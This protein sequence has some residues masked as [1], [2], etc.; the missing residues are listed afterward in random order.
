MDPSDLDWDD[1]RF[2]YHAAQEKTLAGAAR[3]L[4]VKH[5]T[6]GRRITSLERSLKTVLVLR[7]RDGLRLTSAG[8]ALLPLLDDMARAVRAAQQGI[9]TQKVCVRLAVP[10]GYTQLLTPGLTRLREQYLGLSI[11]II[12]GARPVDL[13]KGEADLALRN[14]PISDPDLIAKKVGV[15]GWSLYATK[16][17]LARRGR[18]KDIEDLRGHDLIGYDQ[19]LAS[20]PAAQWI[21]AHAHGASIVLRSREM[22]D[23]VAATLSGIGLA[24]LPCGLG[25]KEPELERLTDAVLATRQISLVYRKEMRMSEELRAVIAYV[26]EV[27]K[28]NAALVSGRLQ[29]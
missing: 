5:S 7:D 4:G 18:P 13:N 24:V 9:A 11:E 21:E 6:I 29:R 2:F 8:E 22:T 16:S 26:T 23:M 20:V 25:D 12:S 15:A 3:K 27:M 1:L 14:G 28:E 17:Y 10:S 19:A